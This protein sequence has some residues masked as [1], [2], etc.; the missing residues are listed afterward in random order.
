MTE[1]TEAQIKMARRIAAETKVGTVPADILSGMWDESPLVRAVLAAIIETQ[2][3]DAI[4]A[5]KMASKQ[6]PAYA[7]GEAIRVGKHYEKDEG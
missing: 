3:A 6:M 4:L 7:V 2:E 1:P 5:W